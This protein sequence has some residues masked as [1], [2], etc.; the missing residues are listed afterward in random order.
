M[1]FAHNQ[2]MKISHGDVLNKSCL[3]TCG[4]LRYDTAGWEIDSDDISTTRE[5]I[6]TKRS[7]CVSSGKRR[8]IV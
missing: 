5:A 3:S 7:G 2:G 8:L 4:P 1:Y 6:F